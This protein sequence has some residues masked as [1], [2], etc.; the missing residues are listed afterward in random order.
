MRFTTYSKF[1]PELADAV[2]LQ[3]LLDQLGDFLLQSGFG[4]GGLWNDDPGEPD[5]GMDALR[6]AIAN[7]VQAARG[8]FHNR[9]VAV[10]LYR[11][12]NAVNEETCYR[13]DI[14]FDDAEW[15]DAVD[16]HHCSCRVA[17]DTTGTASIRRCDDGNEIADMHFTPED[18][19]SNRAADQG[20]CDVVQKAGQH[21]D[22]YEQ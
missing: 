19:P 22:N 10:L 13:G 6:E 2:N 1:L 15:A 4:G 11:C 8:I 3:A 21:E 12:R 5:R 7:H 17:N 16:P 18:M 14:G 20:R 9:R